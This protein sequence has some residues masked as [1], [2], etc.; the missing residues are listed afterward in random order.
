V[1]VNGNRLNK[2]EQPRIGKRNDSGR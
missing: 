1:G 2:R